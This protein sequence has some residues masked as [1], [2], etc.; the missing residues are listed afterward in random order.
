MLLTAGLLATGCGAGT[1]SRVTPVAAVTVG[2]LAGGTGAGPGQDAVRGA[3]LAAE[4]VNTA[5]PDLDLP[6][7]GGAGLPGLGGATLRLAVADSGGDPDTAGTAIGNLLAARAVAV[8]VADQA[9]VVEVAGDHADRREVP[10]LDGASTAGY[11][12]DIGLDWYFRTGPTDRMLTEAGLAVLP[13]PPP[14]RAH[15]VA[16]LTPDGGRGTDLATLLAGQVGAAGLDFTGGVTPADDV[17]AAIAAAAPDVLIAAAPAA[18]DGPPLHA[19]IAALAEV[20]PLLGLDP[21]VIGL[22]Q[23]FA[24][25]VAARSGSDMPAGM[26]HATAWSAELAARHPAATT[27]AALY[28]DRFETPMTGAAAQAFTATL[29]A[30]MAIDAAAGETGVTSEGVRAALRRLSIPATRTIMPW[31]GIRFADTG[32]NLLAAAV[33]EQH[34]HDGARLVHPPEL[35]TADL[36]WDAPSAGA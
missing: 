30:A 10:L 19:A 31:D 22:G 11:L 21:L 16:V 29:T 15:R 33:V 28:Q 8:V 14:E 9:T 17:P 12:L 27:V 1:S 24:A 26:V 32:Q 13:P 34:D 5:Y 4:V 23:G 3:E 25:D 18:A 6:L 36:V 7:A 2:V 35:A 20:D